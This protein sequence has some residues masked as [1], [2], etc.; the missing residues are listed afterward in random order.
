[1]KKPLRCRLR[2]HRWGPWLTLERDTSRYTSLELSFR[3]TKK[4]HCLAC[5]RVD[6]R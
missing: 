5:G 2:W 1:M 4:R 3:F 6:L